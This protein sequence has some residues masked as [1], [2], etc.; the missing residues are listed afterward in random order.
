MRRNE[1]LGAAYECYIPCTLCCSL[2]FMA[3]DKVHHVLS[4]QISDVTLPL[5]VTYV[6]FTSLLVCLGY[7]L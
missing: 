2:V 1:F 6:Y 3:T 4:W 5:H 7:I